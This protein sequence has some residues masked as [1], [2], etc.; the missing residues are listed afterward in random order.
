[1]SLT[2]T[3]NA[4]DRAA[5]LLGWR[6]R[7]RG[8]SLDGGLDQRL[9]EVQRQGKHDRRVLGTAHLDERLQVPQLDGH[10]IAADEFVDQVAREAMLEPEYARDAIKAVIATIRHEITPA[11]LDK[12]LDTV[13]DR[14]FELIAV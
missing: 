13:P 9:D 10:R 3:S 11:A 12:V 1:M 5:V 8:L 4:L 7:S 14:I 2:T 6:L